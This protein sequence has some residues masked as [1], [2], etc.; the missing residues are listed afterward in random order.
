MISVLFARKD[1][2]Y[3][4]LPG[5]HVWDVE[6]NALTWSGCSPV[7][8]HPPCRSWGRLR[9]FAK[10]R[11]G[12]K[13]LAI[14]AIEQV[15]NY[16]GVLEHPSESSL[17]KHCNLPRPGQLPDS[18]GGYTI[19]VDQYHFGHRAEK[20]TWLY[21]VGFSKLPLIPFRPG[22]PTHCV[23][24]SKSYPRLPTITKSEREHTPIDFAKWLVQ[25]CRSPSDLA[26]F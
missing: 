13:E 1:S 10:P 3:K 23:R 24:P 9:Q 15:R 22:S 8:C 7:I 18:F 12:E 2:I 16:G 11:P 19:H 4:T 26:V 25:L 21:I 5:V 20:S 6:R 17:W 14:F